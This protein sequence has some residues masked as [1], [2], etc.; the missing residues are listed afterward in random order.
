MSIE[1]NFIDWYLATFSYSTPMPVGSGAGTPYFRFWEIAVNVPV[2]NAH[3]SY[4]KKI[5][6]SISS[7][8]SI[9]GSTF[10]ITKDS[11]A[12]ATILKNYLAGLG[13]GQIF[14]AD[15][16]D[17]EKFEI[18]SV[19]STD[20]VV[21]ITIQG[22]FTKTFSSADIFIC[23]SSVMVESWDIKS[24]LIT[25]TSL[26]KGFPIDLNNIDGKIR[27]QQLSIPAQSLDTS[28][29]YMECN[30]NDDIYRYLK[31]SYSYRIG[32]RYYIAFR[33]SNSD[34]GVYTSS[35][36]STMQP[37]I[38]LDSDVYTSEQMIN[39]A[40]WFNVSSI[41]TSN[42]KHKYYNFNAKISNT[43]VD[44]TN[45][46]DGARLLKLGLK[47]TSA[48]PSL[49]NHLI[50][51]LEDIYWEHS[52]GVEST[53]G[54]ILLPNAPDRNSINIGC[55]EEELNIDRA[56]NNDG[57]LSFTRGNPN[58][59][60]KYTLACNF[61]DVPL[62]IYNKLKIIETFQNDGFLINL[63]THLNEFPQVLTGY[64]TIKNIK[65]SNPLFGLVSFEFYFEEV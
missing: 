20:A 23:V 14:K 30:L 49:T 53:L 48:N 54:C 46:R 65:K 38:S 43:L 45:L 5:R 15:E 33:S 21:T 27:A 60:R 1:S 62:A 37:I 16:S 12:D 41:D 10:T 64:M 55:V 17:S 8:I 25:P 51:G 26:V 52:G 22:T 29:I 63:H 36:Y 42:S 39:L 31:S 57:F 24:N 50:I 61:N 44:S 9:G 6:E 4:P 2:P 34:G 32:A 35:D 59:N 47:A 28:K 58:A 13:F 56:A 18:A 3:F 40:Y 11:T 7:N 19:T